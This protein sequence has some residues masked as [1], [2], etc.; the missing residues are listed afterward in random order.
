[1][2]SQFK[3][4]RQTFIAFRV[5]PR[6]DISSFYPEGGFGARK[7]FYGMTPPSPVN[8]STVSS[9]EGI[10]MESPDSESCEYLHINLFV[11]WNFSAHS[12]TS[13]LPTMIW[14]FGTNI[15]Y[16]RVNAVDKWRNCWNW[17][18]RVRIGGVV[19][20]IAS[21][22]FTAFNEA[23]GGQ[24]GGRFWISHLAKNAYFIVWGNRVGWKCLDMYVFVL[25]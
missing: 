13:V 21:L 8:S 11:L 10:R 7:F 23:I 15:L 5:V 22:L 6:S 25:I 3:L 16:L 20:K 18:K 17:R 14:L 12:I 19:Q 4:L 24:E 9:S 1:M 2:P